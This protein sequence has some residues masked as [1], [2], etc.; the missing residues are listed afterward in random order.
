[1]L[2]VDEFR[3]PRT[4]VANRERGDKNNIVIPERKP[5]TGV[6]VQILRGDGDSVDSFATRIVSEF[7]CAGLGL[8]ARNVP[9]IQNK[10]EDYV[11][12][13]RVENFYTVRGLAG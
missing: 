4:K 8:A 10:W 5:V 2:H 12:V 9:I 3:S 13:V 6:E 1:M 7:D 11:R